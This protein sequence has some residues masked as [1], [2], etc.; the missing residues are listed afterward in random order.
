MPSTPKPASKNQIAM[1]KI[2]IPPDPTIS[3]PEAGRLLGIGRNSAYVAASCG[4]IPTIRIGRML[5]V[6]K[7]ALMRMLSLDG[8][9]EESKSGAERTEAA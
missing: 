6:P 9:R 3:V 4:Q 2:D 5:R 7:A 8:L 1:T